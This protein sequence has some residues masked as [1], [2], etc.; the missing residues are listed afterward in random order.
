[1]AHAVRELQANTMRLTTG[2]CRS[3]WPQTRPVPCSPSPGRHRGRAAHRYDCISIS[4]IQSS[5]REH[6]ELVMIIPAG[7]HNR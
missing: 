1:M 2:R 3:D 5:K 4:V 6:S 7:L